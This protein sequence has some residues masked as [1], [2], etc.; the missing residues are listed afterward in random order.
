[1]LKDVVNTKMSILV[2]WHA[3]YIYNL[4][5]RVYDTIFNTIIF[6]LCDVQK[7][8]SMPFSCTLRTLKSYIFTL[9]L[10]YFLF[11][12]ASVRAF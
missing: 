3:S 9:V 7:N 2:V 8:I 10:Q 6:H 4:Y 12:L 11:F 1:M 5:A